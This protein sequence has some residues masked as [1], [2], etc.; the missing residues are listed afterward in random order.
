VFIVSQAPTSGG[1]SWQRLAG[2]SCGEGDDWVAPNWMILRP[3]GAEPRAYGPRLFTETRRAGHVLDSL[4]LFG[5]PGPAS[6]FLTADIGE[7]LLF[8]RAL[9]F[10]EADA[11]EAY[12]TRKWGLE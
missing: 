5:P 10:D 12:L 3:G 6:Q 4:V 2:A 7:A 11:I 8:D 9:P 1:P